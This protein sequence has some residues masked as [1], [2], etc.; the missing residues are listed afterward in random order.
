MRRS[1]VPVFKARRRRGPLF[2]ILVTLLTIVLIGGAVAVGGGYWYISRTQPQRAGSVHLAGL[3]SEARVYWDERGIPHIEATDVHDLFFAQGYVTAQDRLWQMDLFRRVAGGRMAE[4]LGEAELEQDK[5]FRILGLRQAADKSLAVI[6]DEARTMGEA[7]AAGVTAY[8]E[9]AVEDGTLPVEFRLLGYTPEPW[10]VEDSVLVG[11]LMA[12]QLSGNWGTEA[13]RYRIG[14]LL[15]WDVIGEWL[16]DYPADAPT[17]VTGYNPL[18]PPPAPPAPEPT[19]G[20]A[21]PPDID[22]DGG[23]PGDDVPER[24]G[25]PSDGD[26]PANEI[27][28]LQG[29]SISAIERL[30][31]FR[32]FA[33]PPALGSNSWAVAPEKTQ[34]GG[35]LLANDP[36]MQYG[37]PALWHQVQLVLE[38]DFSAIGIGVPGVP[39][40]VFG[41]N[42]DI[43]WAITSLAADSQDLYIQ[44]TNP[45][46]PQ[47]F[48][49]KGEWEA[50]TVRTEEIKVKGR[51]EP[52]VIDVV[53]TPRHGPVLTPALPDG[54]EDVISIAWTALGATR[55]MNALL[56]LMRATDF[57]EFETALDDFDMP[58]LSFLYADKAGNIGYKAVGLLPL[59]PDEQ[60]VGRIPVPAWE[61]RYDWLGTIPKDE[62]PRSYNPD[63]G[64]IV[65]ANNLPA[66]DVY[67]HYIGDEHSPW[68]A[69]RIAEVLADGDGFVPEDMSTLQTDALN[70]HARRMVPL[71]TKAIETR[72]QISTSAT[73]A[74]HEALALLQQ[75]DFVEGTE[76]AAPFIWHVWLEKL[77]HVVV[78][79]RLGFSV[80]DGLLLDHL[81]LAMRPAELEDVAIRSFRDAV[82]TAS[83]RQGNEPSRWR[84]GRFHRMTV[85]HPIGEALPFLGWLLNVGDWPMAGS[86]YTPV[87]LDYGGDSG[88]VDHGASWRI[89][90][91]LSSGKGA[92]VLL[93]GNSGHVL[94]D[95][96]KDQAEKWRDGGLF[97]QSSTPERYRRGALLRLLPR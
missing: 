4:V 31:T 64:F 52:V 1:S 46:D 33:P 16:P 58:A 76:A 92:D 14:E 66:D 88:A 74:E 70:V 67:P 29:G 39:G 35:T 6:N 69:L 89:V 77:Q 30:A 48:L 3:G 26:A 83:L 18:A 78:E 51:A 40:V 53:E 94:N 15:G 86:G 13:D 63:A 44:Q 84:W 59:R 79:E 95:S 8:I 32:P 90:V 93:P 87:A 65:T 7:Y 36:H 81:L 5:F 19:D 82:R 43:A 50:G 20:Q 96:Y 17:I 75:W 49:Y 71:L 10:T 23:L 25:P 34:T 42:D 73:A 45:D 57:D 38:G 9:Q 91:D 24:D 12:Y 72:L 61:G 37:I 22:E 27:D 11:R 2:Y 28:W 68:R 85:Y 41:R 62:L 97:E 60:F 80:N 54:T 21:A 55:E 56:P 47:Q